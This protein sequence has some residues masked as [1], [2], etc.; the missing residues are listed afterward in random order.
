ML[1]PTTVWVSLEDVTPAEMRQAQ[2]DRHCGL[3]LLTV[4]R[5]ATSLKQEV[6]QYLPGAGAGGMGKCHFVNVNFHFG[7]KMKEFWRFVARQCELLNTHE[8]Y[9][10]KQL[11]LFTLSL[12]LWNRFKDHL[13]FS[14]EEIETEREVE[15]F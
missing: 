15:V 4:P 1:T 3:Y 12:T 11:F 7:R 14:D 5:I 8:L 10:S 6:D 2:K 13:I 9:A